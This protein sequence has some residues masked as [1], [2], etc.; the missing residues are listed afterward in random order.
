M[1]HE[2]IYKTSGGTVPLIL[3]LSAGLRWVAITPG[4]LPW[5]KMP[6]TRW[7]GGWVGL[8]SDL[9]VF[10]KRKYLT[11]TA[12]R[13]PNSPVSV[14]ETLYLEEIYVWF[15]AH[16]W[17][18]KPNWMQCVIQNWETAVLEYSV[19]HI[20]VLKVFERPDWATSFLTFCYNFFPVISSLL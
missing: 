2:N 17:H 6:G 4:S 7:T 10:Q 5:A 1:L 18:L 14:C 12:V 3:N 20:S 19:N 13:T 16:I 11:S 8:R 9:D 15:S